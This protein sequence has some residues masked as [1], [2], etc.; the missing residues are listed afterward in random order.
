MGKVRTTMP[1]A[2]NKYFIRKANGG[3]STCIQGKPTHKYLDVFSN[4]VGY[5]CGAYNE[6]EGLG[7]EKYHLNCNA[8]NHIERA[9]ASGLSVVSKSVVGGIMVWQKGNTLSGSDGAG[10]VAICIYNDG[11]TIKYA[12]SGY[13]S[14][15]PFWITTTT[16]SNGRYGLSS[17]YKYRGCIAPKTF[18][19]DVG[20]VSIDSVNN[21]SSKSVDE[22][23]KEVIAGKYGNGNDRRN[24]LGSRYNEVQARVNQLL[25]SNAN[26]K[27]VSNNA[28][29]NNSNDDLLLLVKKTIRGDYG[30]GDARKK[31]LGSRYN[32]VQKQVNANIKAGLTRWDNIKLF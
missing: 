21:I 2:G 26:S 31:A 11:H 6:Q 5:V 4:C 12:Q 9:I 22:L 14:S 32:E 20:N 27:P 1:S 24:A 8:E 3:Y 19:P 28:S 25:S 13:G 29:N 23:A 30:N 10:H 17:G 15:N 7:Y 18:K 16:N